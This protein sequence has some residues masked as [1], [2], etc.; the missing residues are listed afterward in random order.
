VHVYLPARRDIDFFKNYIKTMAHFKVNTMI[1]E[2]GGGMRLDRHPE[3]NIAW[4]HFCRAIYDMGDLMLQYGEQIP[5]GPNGRF[6]A[7]IHTELG[8]GS[9]L[10]KAEVKDIVEFARRHQVNLVPE[11]Q[12]LSHTYYLVLA[13]RD[14]AEIPEADWPDSYD[15]SNPK[16]YELLFDVIDEYLEV[17]QPEWVH[18]G[19]DE[20]RA[21]IKGNT[22]KLFAEDVLRIYRYLESRGVRTMMWADH[23]VRGHNMEARGGTEPPAEGGVWYSYPSTEGAAEIISGEA[24][25]I[26]MLNWSWGVT[27]SSDEQLRNQ[28]WQQIFG[29]F[30]GSTQYNRWHERL[31]AEGVLGA[32]ISTWTLADEFSFGQDGSLLNM[33][34]SQNLL[35]SNHSP[36]AE[37]IFEHLAIQM[38]EIRESLSGSQLPSLD[39]KRKRAGYSFVPVDISAAGNSGR[40]LGEEVELNRIPSGKTTYLGWPFL[41]AGGS[42]AFAAVRGAGEEACNIPVESNAASLLFLH[43]ASKRGEHTITYSTNYP[44]DTAEPLGYYRIKYEDGLVETVP[45]RYGGNISRH[46]GGFSN[47]LYFAHTIKLGEDRDGKPV[48]AYAYEWINSR[49]NRR[50]KS[51]DLVGIEAKSGA[52]PVLLALTIVKTPFIE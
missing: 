22:G 24:K 6:Q 14:I 5:L 12:S 8:G 27:R 4:E 34:F 44:E 2:V 28:G 40:S 31:S 1:V 3:I 43:V 33:L 17:F 42:Q 39:V 35:W 29:N 20:W 7:S 16:S 9:W 18:I 47:Q 19:H 23:L 11:I 48:L 52:Y 50:I 15:P 21:G 25:D 10:T 13:H 51:I 26:L 32:E 41:I 36:P 38:P 49:P 37:K 30:Q 45:I 46:G